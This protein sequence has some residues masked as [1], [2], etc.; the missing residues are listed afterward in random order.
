MRTVLVGGG[1][2]LMA[3]MFSGLMFW[4][5][6][7]AQTMARTPQLETPRV[8]SVV[9][10][11]T[12]FRAEPFV[13]PVLDLRPALED[14]PSLAATEIYPTLDPSAVDDDPVDLH[15]MAAHEPASWPDASTEATDRI[16]STEPLIAAPEFLTV[17]SIDAALPDSFAPPL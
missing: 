3:G 17:S 2:A 10:A 4:S 11:E 7:S 5:D 9:Y 1:V 16:G 15:D 14:R 12:D 6:L 8:E 13:Q